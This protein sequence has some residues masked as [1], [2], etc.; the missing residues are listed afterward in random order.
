[1]GRKACIVEVAFD[2]VVWID[3]PLLRLSGLG[4]AYRLE[5]GD[6]GDVPLGS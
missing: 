3:E 4:A 2:H 6:T 1:M 5:S